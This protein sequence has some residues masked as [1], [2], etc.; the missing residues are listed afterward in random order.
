MPVT[1]VILVLGAAIAHGCWNLIL[2]MERG[3]SDVALGA[4]LVGVALVAPS[5]LIWSVRDVPAEGWLL[6]ALSGVFETGYFL[7]LSSAYAVGDLSLV[8]PVARGTAPI[9]VAP[10][11]ILALGERPSPQGLAGIALVVLGIFAG[12]ATSLRG[13]LTAADTRRALVLAVVT[14]LMT[15]GYSLVNK[16]GVALVPVPLYAASVFAVNAA[17]M[18]V[19]LRRRGVVFPAARD[20]RWLAML[21]IGVLMIATYVAVLAAMALAP[22]SYVVAAREISIVVGAALGAVVLRER[23]GALRIAGS[24]IIFAGLLLLA[25]G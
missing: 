12:H 25:L 14:G 20:A 24:G 9:A 15:A 18:T 21:A 10:L 2:K 22:V 6:I 7:A 23:H 13:A 1:A 16:L 4:L 17:L 8:Y 11:A 5:F 3:R 19:I